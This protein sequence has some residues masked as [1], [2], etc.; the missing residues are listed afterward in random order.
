MDQPP[1]NAG[2]L[3]CCFR[4]VYL[5]IDIP[6]PKTPIKDCTRNDRLYVQTLFLYAGFTKEEITL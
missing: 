2:A 3:P 5:L 4:L 6:T 1:I